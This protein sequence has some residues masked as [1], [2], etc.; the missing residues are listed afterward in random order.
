MRIVGAQDLPDDPIDAAEVFHSRIVPEVRF[1]VRV[2]DLPVSIVFSP[3]DYT[4]RGWRLAAVQSLA[5]EAAPGRVNGVA[6]EDKLAI[7]QTIAWLAK[8]PGVTGQLLA[9]R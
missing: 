3:A 8:A 2:G 6:G 4:H 5:R 7:E 9:V 1:A